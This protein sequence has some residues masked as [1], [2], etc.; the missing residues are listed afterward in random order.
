MNK[1]CSNLS[2]VN[3]ELE[4]SL[5]TKACPKPKTSPK[6]KASPILDEVLF[7]PNMRIYLVQELAVHDINYSFDQEEIPGGICHPKKL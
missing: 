4:A 2:E 3:L 1:M 7:N 6:F 5:K